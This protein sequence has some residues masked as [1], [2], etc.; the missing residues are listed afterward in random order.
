[1]K[2]LVFQIKLKTYKDFLHLINQFIVTILEK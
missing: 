1:M 2:Y